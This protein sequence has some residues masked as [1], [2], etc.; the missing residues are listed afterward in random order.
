MHHT[1][2]TMTLFQVRNQRDIPGYFNLVMA[3]GIVGIGVWSLG[4]NQVGHVLFWTNIFAY[5]LLVILLVYKLTTSIHGVMDQ[6]RNHRTA[7]AYFTIIAATSIIG[8]QIDW[9][10]WIAW[11]PAIWSIAVGLWIL[12]SYTFFTLITISRNNPGI[13]KGLDGSWLVSVVATQSIAIMGSHF[14]SPQ[15][16][17]LV[18]TLIAFFMTGCLLYLILI[19][20]IFY[21]LIFMP[22][23]AAELEAPYWIN[24]GAVAITT[25]A[26]SML[27]PLLNGQPLADLTPFI[28]GLTLFFWSIG[29]WWI[30]L[31]LIL[32]IWRHIFHRV[33]LPWTPQGY[34]L[35]YWSMVF[36]LGMYTV[37]TLEMARILKL[38]FLTTLPRY[39]I[40]IALV[41]WIST[42]LGMLRSMVG[43]RKVPDKS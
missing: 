8:I 10:G 9:M 1:A 24:M 3:T 30:P 39:F 12:I 32:G 25:L 2:R 14:A 18:F 29:T 15:Q 37:C 42:A 7:P 35:S 34:D 40:F 6:L 41:A 13:E 20:L 16:Q 17:L 31:L 19:T 23:N 5:L 4:W 36:P 26:G 33:P 38:D 21:R 43:K 22:L 28:K 27:I 11:L